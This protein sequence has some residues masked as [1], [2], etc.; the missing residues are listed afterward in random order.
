MEN[1]NR[2]LEIVRSVGME[3]QATRLEAIIERQQSTDTPLILPL[4]GEF[5]A[6]KTS[7]IN[8][9]TDS[10]A[11]ETATEPTTATIYEIHF[12][13]D[14]CH[15]TIFDM[16]GQS[17]EVED[18]SS[19]KN[20]DLADAKVVTVFDTSTKISPAIFLVDTPGLSSPDPRHKQTLVDFLP[21]ADGILLVAD[22]NQQLTRSLTDFIETVRISQKPIYMVL[23]KSDT[24]DADSIVAAKQYLSENTQLPVEQLVAVSAY[25]D[26]LSEMYGLL[27]AIQQKKQQIIVQVDAQ[28]VK[29]IIAQVNTR[30][31]ELLSA[32]GSD[33][34][35]EESLHNQQFELKRI[36]HN[37]DSITAEIKQSVE[38]LSRTTIRKFED[39]IQPKLMGI[40]TEGGDRLDSRVISAV[41]AL[42]S[43]LLSDYKQNIGHLFSEEIT[44]STQ[45]T[46][47]IPIDC[48]SSIDLS[49]YNIDGF[50][51]DLNLGM[52]GHQYDSMIKKGLFITSAVGV[53]VAAVPTLSAGGQMVDTLDTVT[54][55]GCIASNVRMR[56]T[57]QLQAGAQALQTQMD[58]PMS[59]QPGLIDSV[60]GFVTEKTLSR[61]QRLHVVKD[62]MNNTLIPEFRKNIEILLQTLLETIHTSLI[63]SVSTMLDEK[64]QSLVDMKQTL[65][66]NKDVFE[67]RVKELQSYKQELLTFK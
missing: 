59:E 39:E 1:L 36:A 30:I 63:Q 52:L 35:L 43:L 65:C 31:D 56:R 48:L 16:Q 45:S 46:N 7:L 41:N 21:N 3:T 58:T 55:I 51:Y 6:G 20:T 53:A 64:K 22:I 60:V 19:L 4:V 32:S 42:A 26:D 61:P 50:S 2:L 13:C 11:L 5:S 40:V 8:A 57:L 27:D 18:I 29:D 33:K 17:K 23:T 15:A 47:G 9:L 38:V 44:K 28:R 62:Y 10:R 66:E 14:H 24:K 37:I 49:A 12:G 34:E 25:K 54:D 67:R